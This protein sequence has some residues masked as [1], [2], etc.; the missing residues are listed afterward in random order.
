M[1]C[2]RGGRGI[3]SWYSSF[4]LVTSKTHD[5][6]LIHSSSCVHYTRIQN[7]SFPTIQT[8]R[9]ASASATTHLVVNAVGADRPGIVSEVTKH[10]VDHGGKIGRAH[11]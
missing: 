10:V 4:A 1:L 8:Q 2:H 11:V 5:I 6:R 7:K 9:F 3:V